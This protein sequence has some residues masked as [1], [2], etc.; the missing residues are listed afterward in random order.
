M[1]LK[2]ISQNGPSE[3]KFFKGRVE[4]DDAFGSCPKYTKVA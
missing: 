1:L 3:R 4:A 2:F